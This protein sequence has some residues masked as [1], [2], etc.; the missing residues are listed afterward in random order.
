M[1][2]YRGVGLDN[3]YLSNGYT[4]RKLPSG[5]EALSIHNL[6]G[7]H[8]A[9]AVEL[10]MQTGEMDGKTFCFLR[11]FADMGQRAIGEVLGTQEQTVSTWER[12]ISRVP[13][14]AAE[15]LRAFVRELT[16]GNASL[17]EAVDRY[18]HLDRERRVVEEKLSFEETQDGWQLAA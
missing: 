11:K 7:L 18:N 12:G 4:T 17:Q 14:S 2:R 10:S 15:W 1:I 16:S 8:K 9:I 13:G 3:V 6:Q 5:E